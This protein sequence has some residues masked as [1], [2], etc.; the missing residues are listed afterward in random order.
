MAFYGC[1]F[2]FD[3]IPCFEYGLMVY[4]IGSVTE[5][6]EFTSAPSEILEQ[7]TARRYSP[8]YYG[9]TRNTPL[10]FTFTFGSDI[11]SIESGRWLDRWE[12]DAIST[13]LTG[14]GGY[15]YLEI[16]QPDM[17]VIRYKCIITNLTYTTNGKY[18][19]AFSCTVTC[20]SP[21]AYL[22]PEHIS[23]SITGSG[24]I[25][26]SS[27]QACEYYYPKMEITLTSGNS[28]TIVNESDNNRAFTMT[29]VTTLPVTISVDNENE[30]IT[31]T[32]GTN[33]YNTFNY[34]FLRLV[35]G[36]NILSVTANSADISLVCEYP[37]NVGG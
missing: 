17:D 27:R 4:D 16:I 1:Q 19:W 28:I 35:R 13:W 7:R 34:N 30:I 21:Y 33:L 29:G 15:R 24:T 20:D 8:L 37:I 2:T 31:N 32:Q 26:I 25:T 23:Q 36:D 11:N 18:P 14:K 6:G 9:V 12:M 22:Y 10:E 5:D 3:D